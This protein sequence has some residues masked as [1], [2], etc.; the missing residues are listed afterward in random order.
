MNTAARNRVSTEGSSFRVSRCQ[1]DGSLRFGLASL[2]VYAT[3]AFGERWMYRQLGLLGSYG[4]WTLLFIGFG[5]LALKP[6]VVQPKTKRTF[7]RWFS[8][9]FF[10]YAAGWMASY[11]TLRGAAGEWLGSL[12][13]SATLGL[14]LAI[15]FGAK[16]R[17]ARISLELFG[18][19]SAGYFL[20]E[21]LHHSFH[22]R[23]GML[24]WGVC[25]GLGFGLGLARA[26]YWAQTADNP[27][28]PQP[29]G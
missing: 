29:A 15:V 9:A 21:W 25:Y 5:G 10:A 4:V 17:Y 1:F 28:P 18:A 14:V 6:L 7:W 12:L 26:L 11:F 16:S 8:L 22:G 23:I 27:S 24:L 3:V 20:G 2:L 13:G 19:H